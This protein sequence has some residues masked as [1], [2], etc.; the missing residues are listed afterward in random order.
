MKVLDRVLKSLGKATCWRQAYEAFLAKEIEETR[1]KGTLS[2]KETLLERR[3]I[4]HN[5]ME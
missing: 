3:F 5:E 2:G 4:G 1:H